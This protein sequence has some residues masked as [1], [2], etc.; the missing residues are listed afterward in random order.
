MNVDFASNLNFVQAPTTLADSDNNQWILLCNMY[1]RL[2]AL[3]KCAC[4]LTCKDVIIGFSTEFTDDK[5][6]I[7]KFTSGAGTFI[8][9]GF[10]DCGSVLIIKNATGTTTL[11]INIIITQEGETA[12]IDISM[13][14]SG[15]YLTF[16]IDAKL[17][18]EGISCS[19]CVSKVV[20]NTSGCCEITNNG[21]QD[22][23]LIYKICLTS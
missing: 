20:R 23:T 13:F 12:E 11:P 9:V 10:T 18:A 22:V 7:L 4:K 17:C 6:V 2:K 15:E 16:N 19:K 14:N 1:G 3:E 5:K 8:P 21:T